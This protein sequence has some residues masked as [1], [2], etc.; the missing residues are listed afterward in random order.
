MMPVEDTNP[1]LKSTLS[2]IRKNLG[3]INNPGAEPLGMLA[4][5]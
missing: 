1:N 5:A 4:V 3:L 2:A